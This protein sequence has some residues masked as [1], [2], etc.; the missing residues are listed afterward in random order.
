MMFVMYYIHAMNLRN[1][2]LNLLVAFDALMKER[3]VTRAASQ[4]GMSQPAMS[5]ALRRLRDLIDDP[6]LVRAGGAMVPTA[7]ANEIAPSVREALTAI[8]RALS[9][10]VFD[11]AQRRAV[12]HVATADLTEIALMPP[13]IERLRTEGPRIDL[14]AYSLPRGLP[15]QELERGRFDLA[16]G[17]F[18]DPPTG[19]VLEP[20]MR[21]R[22][23]CIMRRDHPLAGKRLTLKRF[24]RLAHVLVSP[25]GRPG[26]VA[27]RVLADHGL[28][29]R[30][31]LTTPHFLVAPMLVSQSDMVCTIAE[32]VARSFA[33]HLP[34]H[35]VNPPLEV[36][37]FGIDLVWHRRADEDP[38]Q[39]WFR[40]QLRAVA[41]SI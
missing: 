25:G 10:A 31:V 2:D 1:V 27:D 11:P 15:V 40:D 22:F 29:R 38:A 35:I 20:L 23:V 41:A 14:R 19:F 3:G 28:T 7:R 24:A 4:L 32:R 36:P 34:L 37:G 18:S 26:G 21:E 13:L 9:P 16:I 33:A 17:S 5:N 39:R 30:V 6:L 8:G 12:F